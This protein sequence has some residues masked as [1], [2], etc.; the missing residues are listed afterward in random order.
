MGF[1]PQTCPPLILRKHQG[2]PNGGAFHETTGLQSQRRGLSEIGGDKEDIS[3]H[4]WD[5]EPEKALV[6]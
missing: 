6:G 4:K 2:S 1:L 5:P 3:K